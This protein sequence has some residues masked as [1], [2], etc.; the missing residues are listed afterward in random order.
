MSTAINLLT[1]ETHASIVGAAP[2]GERERRVSVAGR[3]TVAADGAHALCF[4]PAGSLLTRAIWRVA[5]S[6]CGM[7]GTAHGGSGPG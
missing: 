3:T 6:G 5:G 4:R 7:L 2:V 1:A